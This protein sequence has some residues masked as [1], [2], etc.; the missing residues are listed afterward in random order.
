MN[1][2]QFKTTYIGT[3]LNWDKVAGDQCVDVAKAYI[4][5]VQGKRWYATGSVPVADGGAINVFEN[6]PNSM[7][8]ADDYEL[9]T[10]NP[11][12]LN[13]F[14][15]QGDIIIWGEYPGL[16]GYDGHIAVVDSANGSSFVSIDQKWGQPLSVRLVNHNYNGVLGWLRVKQTNSNSNQPIINNNNMS[17]QTFEYVK[18]GISDV[19]MDT[20]YNVIPDAQPIG[21]DGL[22]WGVE[23]SKIHANIEDGGQD[24]A[25]AVRMLMDSYLGYFNQSNAEINDLANKKGVAEAIILNQNNS[26]DGFKNQITN[27]QSSLESFKNANQSL[28]VQVDGLNT[29]KLN[30]QQEISNLNDK[31]K[32]LQDQ[33]ELLQK[34][35]N[36]TEK[37]VYQTDEATKKEN[38]DLKNQIKELQSQLTTQPTSPSEKFSFNKFFIGVSKTIREKHL[39]AYLTYALTFIGIEL[40]NYLVIKSPEVGYLATAVLIPILKKEQ[41][42]VTPELDP[43]V[44]AKIDEKINNNITKVEAKL[45]GNTQL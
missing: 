34:N 6:Y 15:V 12:D 23:R 14:P 35:P 18:Q 11:N 19:F 26:I 44:T 40:V 16:T 36:V 22:G 7:V 1:H 4:E 10:N 8:Y 33:V 38:E 29:D 45:P 42:K 2:E 43:N 24:P 28:Q 5:L 9:I 41:A 27:L 3:F 17:Q 31:I 21:G 39:I 30:L 20:K 32:T 13:Q 25:T 37:T